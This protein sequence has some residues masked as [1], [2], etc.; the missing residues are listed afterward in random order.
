MGTE[1]NYEKDTKLF[2]SQT[3]CP[4]VT[5]TEKAIN[6]QNELQFI[7][8]NPKGNPNTANSSLFIYC[9]LSLEIVKNKHLITVER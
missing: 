8:R 3:P 9:Y 2:V 7:T 4:C 5:R 1:Q 6:N